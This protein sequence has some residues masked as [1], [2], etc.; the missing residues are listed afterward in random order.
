MMSSVDLTVTYKQ[1]GNGE[2]QKQQCHTSVWNGVK[3][4]IFILKNAVF[5]MRAIIYWDFD[6]CLLK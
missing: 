1:E 3:Y 4:T 6:I 2:R 5:R